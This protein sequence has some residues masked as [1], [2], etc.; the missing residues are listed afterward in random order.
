[1]TKTFSCTSTDPYDK[2]TYEVILKDGKKL[3]FDDWDDV[4][5]YWWQNYQVPDFLSFVVVKDKKNIRTKG[6]GK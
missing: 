2:H 1:M 5:L 3:I 4:Q 6:F